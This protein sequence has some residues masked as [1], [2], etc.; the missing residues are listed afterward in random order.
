MAKIKMKTRK[1]AAKRFPKATGNGK[2]L[3]SKRNHG[4]FNER[5]GG[6]KSAKLQGTTYVSADDFARINSLVPALG[7]KKKRTKYLRRLAQQA[8][9]ATA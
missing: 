2:I 7:A 3:R 1:A 9:N 8:T 5:L 6:R 4:H